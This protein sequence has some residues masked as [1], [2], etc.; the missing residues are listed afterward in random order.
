MTASVLAI[1][2]QA[3]GTLL[4]AALL[5][6]LTHVIPVR[7]LR[8]WAM[9]WAALAFG[10][11]GLQLSLAGPGFHAWLSAYCAGEYL[12][13]FLLW[14]G[15]R[16]FARGT[17]IRPYEWYFL[18]PF[19]LGSA[20]VPFFFRHI[21]HFFYIHAPILAMFFFGALWETRSITTR[22]TGLWIVRITLLSLGIA[23]L[24]YGPIIAYT[25]FWSEQPIQ[26]EYLRHTAIFDALMELGL[27]FGM[28]I[29]AAERAHKEMSALN[30]KL[31]LATEQ[32]AEAARTDSLTGLLNRRAF[33]EFCDGFANDPHIGC[34]AV[35][36]LN[37]LKPL[38]DLHGH[39]AGDAALQVVARALRNCC[40]VTDPI[41]RVG[42]DEFIVV[43]PSG[44]EKELAARLEKMTD[45]L[46]GQ[47][48][49][50][51]PTPRDLSAAFGVAG[52]GP[53][54]PPTA[55]V[56][57]ADKAM[58]NQKKREKRRSACIEG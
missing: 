51:V 40:R 29:L 22:P 9:S 41:Y 4:V 42:G 23:F 52:F 1:A 35:L 14:A 21:N 2:L 37:E 28:V 46:A 3:I 56:A 15:F 12:F 49:P 43:L 18:A 10:I 13:G 17:A 8:Y 33:D 47:R 7:F 19:F 30:E 55:A 24:H 50:G 44:S 38:N 20:I 53:T 36:D 5:W 27:A 11:V 48:L 16:D 58:Y 32:L 6:Q 26:L 57:M 25:Q 45:S 39:E 31:R 34:L 54:C